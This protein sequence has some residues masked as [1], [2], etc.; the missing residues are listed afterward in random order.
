[1]EHSTVALLLFG[2][3]VLGATVIFFAPRLINTNGRK[4][5]LYPDMLM[6]ASRPATIQS[7]ERILQTPF[8]RRQVL[9]RKIGSFYH[10]LQKRLKALNADTFF[11]VFAQV[12]LG[13]IINCNDDDALQ[14]L[15]AEKVDFCITNSIHMPLLAIDFVRSNKAG[16]DNFVKRHALERAGIRYLQ[17]D[18]LF[19]G[20]F[21]TIFHKRIWP[22]L[23]K[24]IS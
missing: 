20:S 14:E 19:D 11:H 23:Q 4:M 12:H 21:E 1:M 16:N 22:L 24:Y 2:L 8:R 6:S 10:D 17:I 13:G 18:K 5:M 3:L 15:N 7:F 9:D